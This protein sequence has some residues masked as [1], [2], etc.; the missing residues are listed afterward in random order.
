MPNANASSLLPINPGGAIMKMSPLTQL[1]VAV[2]NNVD[3]FYFS[4]NIHAHVL[5]AEDG[6]M[7]ERSVLLCFCCCLCRVTVSC[8]SPPLPLCHL[9]SLSL[10]L[11]LSLPLSLS[12]RK[13]FLA[14]WKEIPP[15]NEVQ[16][17]VDNVSLPAGIHVL[18]TIIH[19]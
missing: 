6:N 9:L 14:T 8:H 1:Q 11:S 7:G 19:S 3:V 10:S 5:F 15:S 18:N 4:T 13:V 16:G 12:D 2:K 17:A